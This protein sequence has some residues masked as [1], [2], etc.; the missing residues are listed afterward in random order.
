MLFLPD[1]G[2]QDEENT[3]GGTVYGMCWMLMVDEENHMGGGLPSP[4]ECDQREVG[5]VSLQSEIHQR[6]I[7]GTHGTRTDGV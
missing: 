6:A 2:D 5:Y 3:R 7:Y 4:Q 1:V